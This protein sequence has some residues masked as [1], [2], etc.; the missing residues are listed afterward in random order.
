ME[1]KSVAKWKNKKMGK[2]IYPIKIFTESEHS[3]FARVSLKKEKNIAL[4]FLGR[5]GGESKF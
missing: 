2:N 4:P 1:K 5:P 3:L